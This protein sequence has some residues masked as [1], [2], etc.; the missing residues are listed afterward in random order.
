L[1]RVGTVRFI[2]KAVIVP[3]KAA[4]ARAVAGDGRAVAGAEGPGVA[5]ATVTGIAGGTDLLPSPSGMC[6]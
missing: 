2:A 3:N 5:A 1:N 6:L 4:A